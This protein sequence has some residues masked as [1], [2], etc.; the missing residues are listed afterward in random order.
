VYGQPVT[1]TATVSAVN[2]VM[3][4]PNGTVQFQTNGMNFGSA[5]GL[6]EG[7]A[8]SEVLPATLPPGVYTVTANYSGDSYFTWST[9]TLTGGQAIYVM[10]EPRIGPGPAGEN[11][12][13]IEWPG[14]ASWLYT[15]QYTPSLCPAMW[16][17]LPAFTGV[18]GW[19]GTMSVT[20]NT[21]AGDQI[22]YRI[23][24]TR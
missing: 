5:S 21:G 2:P 6:S 16:S 12:F 4:T 11:N 1:F 3:G 23:Q 8:T 20:N 13:T 7:S 17:N 9:G 14:T 19:D 22:F 15:I 24:M 18:T 10:P